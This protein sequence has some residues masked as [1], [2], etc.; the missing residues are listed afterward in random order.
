MAASALL[1]SD[2]SVIPTTDDGGSRVTPDRL[3]SRDRAVPRL[4]PPLSH[5]Q[6]R[7]ANAS[8]GPLACATRIINGY[9]SLGR[10]GQ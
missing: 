8:D 2:S 5:A 3:R 10:S 1:R 9:G 7:D 4:P 6:S